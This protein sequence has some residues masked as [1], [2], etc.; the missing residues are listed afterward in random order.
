MVVK[1]ADLDKK[2]QKEVR[3]ILKAKVVY[4]YHNKIDATGHSTE[5]DTF[6]AVDDTIEQLTRFIKKLHGSYNVSKVIVTADHGFLY[7][8]YVIEEREKEKGSGLESSISDS[9]FEISSKNEKPS[10][11]YS[12]PLKSTTKFSEDLFVIIPNSVNRYSGSGR[13]N[14]YVHGGASLQEVVV[15]VIESSRKREE[16][17]GL[18]TPSLVTKDLK[19]VSNVL[20]FI[21]IQEEPVSA[22]DKERAIMVGLYKDS[23]LVSNEKEMELNKTSSNPTD[24]VFQVELHLVQ[25]GK[26]ETQYKLK[27]FDKADSNRLNALLE[28]D[29]KNQT[30]IQT[31]F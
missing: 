25:H 5:S 22:S 1:Y 10:L 28:A 21:L 17:S 2:G 18:V 9:R 29:V 15:P 16:V 24:R 6:S 13:G 19:V 8:D 31:D 26:M 30:L 3:D 20:K 7:N 14:Q 23:Q 4:I 12:F 27:V 11:G